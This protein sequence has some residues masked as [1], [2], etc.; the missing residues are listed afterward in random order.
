MMPTHKFIDNPLLFYTNTSYF[1]DF[2]DIRQAWISSACITVIGTISTFFVPGKIHNYTVEQ[3]II[4]AY[5]RIAIQQLVTI[6]GGFLFLQTRGLLGVAVV[7]ILIRFVMD[8]AFIEARKNQTFRF[9]MDSILFKKAPT[10]SE[11]SHQKS[12][13]ALFDA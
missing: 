5:T 2:P 10:D 13:D 6:L 12:L 7:I 3:L 11:E 9:R 8:N 1:L 4:P